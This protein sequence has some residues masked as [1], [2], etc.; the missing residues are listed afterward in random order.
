[1]RQEERQHE[2]NEI[3]RLESEIDRFRGMDLIA[4]QLREQIEQLHAEA[5]Q[6]R[7]RIEELEAA[8][9]SAA[10]PPRAAPSAAPDL[11]G[12]ISF[13]SP[14]GSPGGRELPQPEPSGSPR[15]GPE[16]RPGPA[17]AP[18]RT[19]SA[20]MQS[21]LLDEGQSPSSW[22][23][24]SK[25][26]LAT[27]LNATPRSVSRRQSTASSTLMGIDSEDGILF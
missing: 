11:P 1:M 15:Q 4:E 8:L 9:A 5:E 17:I 2:A 6:Y 27:S 20:A 12:D 16:H 24:S 19:P 10:E 13:S 22:L 3:A 18:V 26:L 7:H 25:N 23:W 14:W 21:E